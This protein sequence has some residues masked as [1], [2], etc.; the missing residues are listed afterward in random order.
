MAFVPQNACIYNMSI[1]ENILF[2][3]PLDYD[4]YMPVINACGL[5]KDMARLPAG[6]LTEVGEKGATLSGGQKQRIALARAVYSDSSIYLLD[7]TLS[8]L[9]VHVASNIFHRVI[10]P[11]GILSNKVRNLGYYSNLALA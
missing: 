10:G 3:K 4:Y 11:R 6:D 9:D 8:A 1:R 2:G 7:D 5:L